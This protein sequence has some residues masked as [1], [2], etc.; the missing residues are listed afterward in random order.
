MPLHPWPHLVKRLK[1]GQCLLGLDVGSKT[2]GVAISD[3]ALKMA[4]PLETIMRS[5]VS[6]DLKALANLAGQRQAGGFVLG[7][8]LNEDGGR[9]DAARKADVFAKQMMEAKDVFGGEPHISFFDERFSTQ[10][11]EEFLINDVDMSRTRRDD[12][13][14]KMAARIILQDALDAYHESLL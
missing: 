11:A 1:K 9:G 6:T 13:I 5:K 3:P 10:R 2:I 14:D 12:V 8:P 4:M 7:L